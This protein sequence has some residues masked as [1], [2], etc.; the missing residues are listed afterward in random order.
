MLFDGLILYVKTV[1]FHLNVS[2]ERFLEL[3]KLFE[4]QYRQLE[5]PMNEIAECIGKLGEPTISTLHEFV[6]YP[7]I[8]EHP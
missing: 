2:V 3:H 8:K 6:K 4:L 1:K 5:E 7:S